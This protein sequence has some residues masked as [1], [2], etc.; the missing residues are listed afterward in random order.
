[1]RIKRFLNLLGIS[2]HLKGSIHTLSL[3]HQTITQKTVFIA[4]KGVYHD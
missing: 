4:L 1:M 3:S 2:T